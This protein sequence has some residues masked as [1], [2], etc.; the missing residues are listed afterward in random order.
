MA[1]KPDALAETAAQV[2]TA[3][4]AGG[5]YHSI[6]R[7]HVVDVLDA[8]K[9]KDI[10]ASVAKEFGGIDILVHCAGHLPPVA[11][12]LTAD[13]TNFLKG[14]E[15]TVAGSCTGFSS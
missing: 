3:T 11:P 10:M 15:T 14:F 8:P 7:T 6:V 4:I 5:G 9:L 12:L 13:P 2:A 1:T